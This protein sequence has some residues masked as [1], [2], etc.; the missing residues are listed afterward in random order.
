MIKKL[1]SIVLV[2]AGMLS[3]KK[4]AIP[5]VPAPAEAIS[6]NNINVPTGFTWENSRN[7]N[8]SIGIIGARFPKM[9]HVVGVYDAA[10]GKLITKGSA[11]NEAPF[12]SKIYLSNQITE[13]YILTLF[14]NGTQNIQRATVGTADVK[15]MIGL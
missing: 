7:I 5:V 3:C 11:T 10:N 13:I 4:D 14:P 2:S 1:L 9:I 6:M 8:F 12:K 15:L